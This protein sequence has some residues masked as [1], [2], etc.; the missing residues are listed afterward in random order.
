MF[1]VSLQAHFSCGDKSSKE[2]L[3]WA[4]DWEEALRGAVTETN[5]IVVYQMRP[6]TLMPLLY[7]RHKLDWT[8]RVT[9]R[10]SYFAIPTNCMRKIRVLQVVESSKF[11]TFVDSFKR[12]GIQKWVIINLCTLGEMYPNGERNTGIPK[13]CRFGYTSRNPG[14]KRS[15]VLGAE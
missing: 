11:G 13:R 9:R 8:L 3:P 2:V 12:Q 10:P 5:D 14:P 7:R 6:Q 1:L 15:S 4:G